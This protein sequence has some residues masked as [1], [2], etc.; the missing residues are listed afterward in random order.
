ML[1]P[2]EIKNRT[3]TAAFCARVSLRGAIEMGAGANRCAGSI[4]PKNC[5]KP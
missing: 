4:A 2:S 5:P 1:L 3:I